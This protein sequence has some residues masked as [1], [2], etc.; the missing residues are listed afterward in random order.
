M[1]VVVFQDGLERGTELVVAIQEHVPLADQEAIFEVGEF[2]SDLFH[3]GGGRMG[4][5]TDEVH[6]ARRQLHDEQQIVR[7][8]AALGPD[9]Q[10]REV[11]RGEDIPM[12]LDE[13]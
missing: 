8:Q 4:R 5:A 3:P 1:D 12:R 13:G 7:D 2:P 10:G 6:S 11:D 9:F